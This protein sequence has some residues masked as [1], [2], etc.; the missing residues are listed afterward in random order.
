M[1]TSTTLRIKVTQ[2]TSLSDANLDVFATSVVN[3]VDAKKDYYSAVQA[4]FAELTPIVTAYTEALAKSTQTR[5]YDDVIAKNIAKAA[6]KEQLATFGFALQ[7]KCNGDESY[8]TMAGYQV[9]KYSSKSQT[10]KYDA[11]IVLNLI[12][13]GEP[14]TVFFYLQILQQSK[15]KSII[16]ETSEDNGVTW[17]EARIFSTLRNTVSN[18]PSQKN[19]GFRFYTVDSRDNRSPYSVVT[20]VSIN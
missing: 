8:I 5:A 14:G 6:L 17:K 13:T 12:A 10:T 11:P 3:K 1:A 19:V 20:I 18:L 4:S 2:F 7:S 9:I 15:I 16:M